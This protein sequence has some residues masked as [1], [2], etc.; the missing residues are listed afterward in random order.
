MREA[1][2]V[3]SDILPIEFTPI[4]YRMARQKNDRRP[5]RAFEC[6]KRARGG[7]NSASE[8][9]AIMKAPFFVQ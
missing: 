7:Y 5:L 4:P 6:P 1:V 2:L 9:A 3:L 8:N